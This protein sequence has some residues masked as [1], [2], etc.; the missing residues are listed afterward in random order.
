MTD[1]TTDT[2]ETVTTETVP[3]LTDMLADS[4]RLLTIAQDAQLAYEQSLQ[5]LAKAH[6]ATFTDPRS[7]HVFQVRTRKGDDTKRAITYLCALKAEPKTWLTGRKKATTV[8]ATAA[9]AAASVVPETGDATVI[10]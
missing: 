6:G 9:A 7:A 2:T 10:E 3:S 1:A 8:T 4:E 5:A